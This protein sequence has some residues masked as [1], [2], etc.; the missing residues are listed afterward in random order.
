MGERG[1]GAAATGL[2]MSRVDPAPGAS[3][4]LSGVALVLLSGGLAQGG[5]SW[6]WVSVAGR[7]VVDV[8]AK[9]KERLL[10]W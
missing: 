1:Q 4:L 6:A 2:C 9:E 10:G 5:G 3:S 7:L 8:S